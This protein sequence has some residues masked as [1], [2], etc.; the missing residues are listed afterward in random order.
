M[1]DQA[2]GS[3]QSQFPAYTDEQMEAV[4][5]IK[6]LGDNGD[7]YLILGLTNECSEVDVIRAYRRLALKVHPDKNK[8]PGAEDA[9]KSLL[10]AYEC[11]KDPGR[12]SQYDRFGRNVTPPRPQTTQSA[13][14]TT[15]GHQNF[16]RRRRAAEFLF[17]ILVWFILLML[18]LSCIIAL[19]KCN[20][21]MLVLASN[22]KQTKSTTTNYSSLIRNSVYVLLVILPAFLRF[23][24]QRTPPPPPPPQSGPSDP[25]PGQATAPPPPPPP[26]PSPPPPPPSRTQGAVPVGVHTHHTF[27]FSFADLLSALKKLLFLVPNLFRFLKWCILILFSIILFLKENLLLLLAI[28]LVALIIVF[29]LLVALVLFIIN[30]PGILFAFLFLLFLLFALLRFLLNRFVKWI[31]KL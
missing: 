11:L 27:R 12:R 21:W 5:R 29:I 20:K 14:P 2:G 1:G 23:H 10:E 30:K 4:R 16:I 3:S 15:T 28:I 19:I 26:P 17:H 25:D 9:F 31:E 6:M 18:L 13:A 8:A 22:A 24:R 7:Y